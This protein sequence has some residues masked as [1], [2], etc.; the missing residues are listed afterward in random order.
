MKTIIDREV[1]K[2]LKRADRKKMTEYLDSVYQVGYEAG[3]KDAGG[4]N[5]AEVF[6]LI[7]SVKGIGPVKAKQ[8]VEV[9]NGEMDAQQDIIFPCGNCGKDLY[10]EKGADFC[11]YCGSPLL[12]DYEPEPANLPGQVELFEEEK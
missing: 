10:H 4:L 8:I 1:Y 12:W 2:M 7:Q 11:P 6:R 3:Q 9:L 5:S